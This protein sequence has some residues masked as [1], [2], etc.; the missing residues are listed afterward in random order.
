MDWS[1]GESVSGKWGSGLVSGLN[2]RWG[3]GESGVDGRGMRL[4]WVVGI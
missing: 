3:V 1:V 2:S 4:V